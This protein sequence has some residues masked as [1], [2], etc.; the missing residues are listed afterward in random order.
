MYIITLCSHKF[1]SKIEFCDVE[2]LSTRGSPRT[3]YS[4]A[5]MTLTGF[6]IGFTT[7]WDCY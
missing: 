5:G 2:M 7:I 3:W 1:P 6:I 4:W